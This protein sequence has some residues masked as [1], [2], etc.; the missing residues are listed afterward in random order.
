MANDKAPKVANR[1]AYGDLPH[2][3]LPGCAWDVV[4]IQGIDFAL[5]VAE[6]LDGVKVLVHE[7]ETKGAQ[8]FNRA[9]RIDAPAKL[10]ARDR[11]KLAVKN[12]TLDK[13]LATLQQELY[14]FDVTSIP[15]RA[16]RAPKTVTAPDQK[17]YSRAEVDAML[18]AQGI[19]FVT[20]AK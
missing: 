1:K 9:L 6:S 16:A 15:T 10:D 17:S 13:V 4:E 2:D 8:M 7:N 14:S 19:K 18:A 20:T 11:I 5:M 3:A 12:G